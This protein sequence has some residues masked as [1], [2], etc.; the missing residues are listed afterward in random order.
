MRAAGSSR[1][2]WRCCWRRMWPAAAWQR[3]ALNLDPDLNLNIEP[4]VRVGRG[5]GAAG[6]GRGQPRP[7]NVKL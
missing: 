4:Q 1:A 7:G 5:G 2:R 3:K 6:D